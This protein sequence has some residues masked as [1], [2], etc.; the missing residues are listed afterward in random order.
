[1]NVIPPTPSGELPLTERLKSRTRELHLRAE[2][3]G[4]MGELIGGRIQA[5]AYV[6]LLSNLLCLYGALEDALDAQAPALHRLGAV[7]PRANRASALRE[8]LDCFSRAGWAAPRA[9]VAGT[10][11][12]VQRLRDVDDAAAHRLIAHAYVRLL[13]DLHGGQVLARIVRQT[14]AIAP[15]EGTRFYE[16]GDAARVQALRDDFRARLAAVALPRALADE[17]VAEACWSFE[18]HCTMF[19]QI[20]ATRA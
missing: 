15:G 7:M 19:E 18:Q 4:V 16:F 11:A 5:P 12:Y 10:S 13:G 9:P 1:V 17:V 8:D 20:N 14:F 6:A 3:S 2:R